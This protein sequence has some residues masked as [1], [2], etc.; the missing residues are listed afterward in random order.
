[1]DDEAEFAVVAFFE[2]EGFVDHGFVAVLVGD[3]D[4]AHGDGEVAV[5][6]DAFV[7]FAEVVEA[8]FYPG[9]E[10]EAFVFGEVRIAADEVGEGAFFSGAEGFVSV[11]EGW[12]EEDFAVVVVVGFGEDFGGDGFGIT[13]VGVG[14]ADEDEGVAPGLLGGEDF[15][16]GDGGGL[17]GGGC[18]LFVREGQG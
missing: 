2:D 7:A 15:G 18:L 5:D 12:F 6:L 13:A 17:G 3:P 16:F 9:F 14:F 1:M 10:G 8:C 4:V 11:G